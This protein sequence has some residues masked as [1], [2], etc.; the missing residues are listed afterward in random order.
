VPKQN[1]YDIY[2][3]KYVPPDSS[4]YEA[5]DFDGTELIDNLLKAELWEDMN[6]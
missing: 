6:D 1:E 5:E 2:G 3:N 4:G